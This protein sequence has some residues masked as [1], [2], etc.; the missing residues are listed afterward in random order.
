MKI[1]KEN[2]R[3]EE[4]QSTWFFSHN[5]L[6]RENT[7]LVHLVSRVFF[8]Y[9]YKDKDIQT[10]THTYPQEALFKNDAQDHW[11]RSENTNLEEK[12]CTQSS[13]QSSVLSYLSPFFNCF[14]NT[15]ECL[16]QNCSF[17]H[18][19]QNQYITSF[20]TDSLP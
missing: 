18:Q 10:S 9:I 15:R 7:G 6:L 11:H 16:E 17:V 14:T 8:G 13:T 4:N 2:K 5:K 19:Y 3:M 20:V 1:S 12:L